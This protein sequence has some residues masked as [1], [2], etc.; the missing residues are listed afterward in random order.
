MIPAVGVHHVRLFRRA[1]AVDDEI[2]AA[3]WRSVLVDG[4]RC[5]TKAL[6]LDE[7]SRALTLPQWFG[8]NWD[9]LVDALRDAAEPAAAG[10]GLAIVID[11]AEHLGG[12]T[13]TLEEIV[14]GLVE[15]GRPIA[16]YLRGRPAYWRGVP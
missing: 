13:A 5:T 14:V 10:A 1:D 9:A 15:E 7:L 16:L 8:H 6:L 11:R 4:G 3:G 12:L 2:R